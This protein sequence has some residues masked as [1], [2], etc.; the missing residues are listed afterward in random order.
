GLAAFSVSQNGVLAYSSANIPPKTQLTWFDR[1]GKSLGSI[2]S[3]GEIEN[4]TLS[5]DE[6]QVALEIR[7]QRFRIGEIWLLDLARGTTSRITS[8]TF[9][10]FL[11]LWSPDGKQIVFA[12]NR[13]G[14]GDLYQVPSIGG[15]KEALLFSSPTANFPTSWSPDG[16]FV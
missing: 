6:K 12:S 15:A 14:P 5:P 7:N 1:T 2:G 9:S 11:P 3:V 16:K 8:E 10:D 13:G 4:V